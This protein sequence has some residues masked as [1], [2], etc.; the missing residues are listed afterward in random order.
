MSLLEDTRK[1]IDMYKLGEVKKIL[2]IIDEELMKTPNTRTFRQRGIIS[3]NYEKKFGL[4]KFLEQVLEINPNDPEILSRLALIFE[5]N[6]NIENASNFADKSLKIDSDNKTALQVKGI[7]AFNNSEYESSINYFDKILTKNEND[8]LALL[9][10]GISLELIG[11]NTDAM[12][13]FRKLFD[14]DSLNDESLDKLISIIIDFT[15]SEYSN[16][17]ADYALT[18]QSNDKLALKIKDR[19]IL[20][21]SKLRQR[22]FELF[23]KYLHRPPGQEGLDWFEELIIQGTKFEE[24]EEMMKNSDEG[25]NYWN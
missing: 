5:L 2:N 11:K 9:N 12:D 17:Y 20:D 4:K 6:G 13:C 19:I 16:V 21:Q 1:L 22:I 10:K 8:S 24:I 7:I 15:G 3:V 25:K 14:T 18:K 23:N